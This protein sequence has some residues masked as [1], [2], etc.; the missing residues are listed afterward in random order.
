MKTKSPIYTLF[1]LHDNQTWEQ[2]SF[3]IV[4]RGADSLSEHETRMHAEN[5][6]GGFTSYGLCED[7]DIDEEYVTEIKI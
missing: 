1:I 6:F 2:P 5:H 7:D 4:G 3:R